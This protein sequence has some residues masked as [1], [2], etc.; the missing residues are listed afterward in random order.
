MQKNIKTPVIDLKEWEQ[1]MILETTSDERKGSVAKW[2]KAKGL[3]KSLISYWKYGTRKPR[4]DLLKK[5]AEAFYGSDK[6]WLLVAQKLEKILN[7]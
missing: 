5:F 3:D 1:T 7:N 2:L 4:I 6:K